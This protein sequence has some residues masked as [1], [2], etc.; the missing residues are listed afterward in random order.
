M[1]YLPETW[2]LLYP[3]PLFRDIPTD[4]SQ[5]PE[6]RRLTRRASLAK[7]YISL[8]HDR[9]IYAFKNGSATCFTALSI[10]VRQHPAEVVDAG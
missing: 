8:D 7:L 2:I 6:S 5:A 1:L 9:R 3:H 4:L 10:V